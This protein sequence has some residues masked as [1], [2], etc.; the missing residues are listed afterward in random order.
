MKVLETTGEVVEVKKDLHGPIFKFKL[1]FLGGL[2]AEITQNTVAPINLFGKQLKLV[3]TTVEPMQDES[4]CETCNQVVI[5][6]L[7]DMTSMSI[8]STG[9]Q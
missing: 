1:L 3:V 7:P 6:G 2:E 9:Q 4:R 5:R 8:R